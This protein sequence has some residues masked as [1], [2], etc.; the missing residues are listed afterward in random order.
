[1]VEMYEMNSIDCEECDGS[2]VFGTFKSEK[3]KPEEKK[4]LYSS[5]LLL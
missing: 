5:M 4:N 2:T 1:M 3:E